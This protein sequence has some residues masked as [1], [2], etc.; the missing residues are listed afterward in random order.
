MFDVGLWI[1]P[2]FR[3]A[4][5]EISSSVG[6]TTWAAIVGPSKK[7]IDSYSRMLVMP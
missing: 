1:T 2:T 7:P 4:R 5:I 3:R 6:Q